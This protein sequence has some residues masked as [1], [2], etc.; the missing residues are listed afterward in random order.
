MSKKQIAGVAVLLAAIVLI[1]VPLSIFEKRRAET[2]AYNEKWG[3]A[4]ALAETDPKAKYIIDHEELYSEEILDLFRSDC[5]FYLDFVYAYPEHKD[6][7]YSMSYTDAELNSKTVPALYM[8]D[9]RWAYQ[10]FEGGFIRT[11][12]CAAVCI[13]MAYLYLK[14]SGDTDPYKIALLAEENDVIG[15]FGGISDNGVKPICESIGLNC[16]V[17][18]Y[19]PNLKQTGYVTEEEIK[20]VIDSG[21][22]CIAGMS[23][24]TFGGHA[25]IIRAYDENGYYI[26]DPASEENTAKVWDFQVFY[27]ELKCLYDVSA[28]G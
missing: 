12:G 28:Q 1:C 16:A 27:N 4:A 26:N 14:N 7:Y 18:E 6:D 3:D 20:A 17:T 8:N 9:N 24:D 25:L 10:S 19:A 15:F 23:G 21:H 11:D 22:V 5:E 2:Q 13:A